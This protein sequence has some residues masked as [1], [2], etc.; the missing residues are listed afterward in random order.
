MRTP[1]IEGLAIRG[2]PEPCAGVREDVGEALDQGYVQAG[3]LS[4]EMQEV[5][6]ADAVGMSGRRC[7]WRRYTRAVSGPREVREPVHARSLHA[8]EPGD[9]TVA[10]PAGDGGGRGRE[11]KAEAVIP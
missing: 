3:L 8:R 2:G 5:R 1:Y 6:G 11:G 10:P 7:R 4:R 9:P